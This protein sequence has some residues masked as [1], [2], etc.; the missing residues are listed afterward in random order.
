M[1]SV[2]QREREAW[3]EPNVVHEQSMVPEPSVLLE[4]ED[5]PIPD[6]DDQVIEIWADQMIDLDASSTDVLEIVAV[7]GGDKKRVEVDERKIRTGE[8]FSRATEAEL[9]SW[10]DHRVVDV[11]NEWVSDKDRVMRVRWCWRGS[12]PA[13]PM[14]ASVSWGSRCEHHTSHVVFSH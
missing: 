2:K 14:H 11:V 1:E 9:Q 13:K 6:A 4:P 7:T 3:R 8:S 10:L 5:V 12:P